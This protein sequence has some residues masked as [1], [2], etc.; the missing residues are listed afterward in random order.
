MHVNVWLVRKFGSNIS[1]KRASRGATAVRGG[2]REENGA[3]PGAAGWAGLTSTVLYWGGLR[4][5]EE[6][7]ERRSRDGMDRGGSV[8]KNTYCD[9][10]RPIAFWAFSFIRKRLFC[11]V[12]GAAH[13][14]LSTEVQPLGTWQIRP[15]QFSAALA[16]RVS[17]LG[18]PFVTCHS[19]AIVEAALTSNIN[20]IYLQLLLGMLCVV[21]DVV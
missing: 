4:G 15:P 13:D 9:F 1:W 6:K 17:I 21:T 10:P 16:S 3:G 11:K 14:R 2:R 19:L 20:Y 5:V 12:Q 18:Q 8:N 7:A